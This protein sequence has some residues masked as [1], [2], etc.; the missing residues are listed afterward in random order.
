[1]AKYSV[2]FK[3]M[4]VNE[5]L[6]GPLGLKLL[7]SKHNI[8]SPNQLR[9]WVMIYKEYGATGLSR[10]KIYETY[11]VQFKLDVLSFMKRTGASLTE[12]ALHFGLTNPP[13]IISWNKKFLEGGTEALDKPRG[14]PVM[15]GKSKNP[16]KSKQPATQNE[17]TRE[18]LLEQENELLRLEI[19]YLKKLEAFQ[20]DP[21][22][23]LE[24]HKQRYH[25]NSKKTSN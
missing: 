3:L 2:E 14:R 17:M 1:M 13:M 12:T 22:G 18:Q 6:V 11:S 23:Y 21:G 16:K 20:M 9:N 5:Y 8:K 4:V 7:A 19:A 15:P 25:S 24:K 10:K